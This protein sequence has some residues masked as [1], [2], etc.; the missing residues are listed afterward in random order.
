MTF[1]M[2]YSF[3]CTHTIRFFFENCNDLILTQTI[4]VCNDLLKLFQF[5]E[6]NYTSLSRLTSYTAQNFIEVIF[7]LPRLVLVSFLVFLFFNLK[8][9]LFQLDAFFFCFLLLLLFQFDGF[10]FLKKVISI[11][12]T[13]HSKQFSLKAITLTIS[14]KLNPV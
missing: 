5:T 13:G 1:L 8:S 11:L 12:L 10:E 7:F 9:I 2:F 6:M 14:P 3:N 4:Y